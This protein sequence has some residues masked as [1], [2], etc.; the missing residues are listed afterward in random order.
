MLVFPY[1][2]KTPMGVTCQ[3]MHTIKYSIQMIVFLLFLLASMFYLRT[4]AESKTVQ[5]IDMKDML[6]TGKIM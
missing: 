1:L 5:N 3:I 4:T 6:P 2:L